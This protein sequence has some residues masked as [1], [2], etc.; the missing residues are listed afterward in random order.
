MP[1]THLA[2]AVGACARLQLSHG[3]HAQ[4]AVGGKQ[5]EGGQA[6]NNLSNHLACGG[7][8]VTAGVFKD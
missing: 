6:R 2:L 8:R 7:S 3:T 1:T 4:R 5:V